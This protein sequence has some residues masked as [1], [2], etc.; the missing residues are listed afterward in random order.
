[1][2]CGS[3]IKIKN[4]TKNIRMLNILVKTENKGSDVFVSYFS[5]D[6]QDFKF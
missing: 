2:L 3:L 1:M 5:C 6:L 4:K